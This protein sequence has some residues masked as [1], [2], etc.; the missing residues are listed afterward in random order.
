MRFRRI[1]PALALALFASCAPD[2]WQN[3]KATG[4]NDYLDTVG[5]QCQPLWIGQHQLS[6]IS[7]DSA[8]GMGQSNFGMFL[9]NTSQL[10]Y[11]RM[12]AAAYRESI[13]SVF[14]AYSDPRTNRSI[15][16]II[17]KLP[18]DRPSKPPGGL[19]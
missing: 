10:Y 15:D 19:L 6:Q 12:S 3:Y 4:F 13:Q 7:P 16:C 17:A 2:A 18:V 5:A 1:A 14:N 11:N 8:G 9:D